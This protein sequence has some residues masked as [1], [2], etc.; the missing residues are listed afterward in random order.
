MIPVISRRVTLSRSATA[1]AY[2]WLSQVA[3]A[4]AEVTLQ[5]L[6]RKNGKQTKK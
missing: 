2:I 1:I 6:V 4:S 5:L 3:P